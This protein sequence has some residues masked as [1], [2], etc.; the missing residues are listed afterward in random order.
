MLKSIFNPF[1]DRRKA[2]PKR[3]LE[4]ARSQTRNVVGSPWGSAFNNY[5]PERFNIGIL[6]EL[7]ANIPLL[8]AAIIKRQLLVGGYQFETFGDKGFKERLDL[9]NQTVKVNWLNQGL[10]TWWMELMD[11]AD[12]NGGGWGELVPT[13]TGSDIYHLKACKYD[14]FKFMAEES[15]KLRIGI[16]SENTFNYVPAEQEDYLYYL[17]FNQ[18]DGHPQGY[19]LLWGLPF[20][21]QILMRIWKSWDNSAWRFADPAMFITVKGGKDQDYASAKKTYDSILSSVSSV[22]Q[23]KHMGQTGDIGGA[24]KEGGDITIRFL[25]G[26]ETISEM[27]IPV[28]N[29]LEQ[30]ISATHIPPVLFGLNWAT[31]TGASATT[32]GQIDI[33]ISLI[34]KQ[35]ER[36]SYLLERVINTKL[37][38]TGD[39]GKK[40]KIIWDEINL[41]DEV[42]TSQA[43]KFNAEASEKEVQVQ[44][45]LIE[46]GMITLEEAEEN[47]RMR[48]LLRG[49]MNE[50]YLQKR[51]KALLVKKIMEN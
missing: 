6:R 17:A 1:G 13:K 9:F 50:D 36:I 46:Q 31:G 5:A 34:S 32:Q 21:G 15:G 8:N 49:K 30:I 2:E 4:P 3:E 26:D 16:K 11:S 18:R 24:V 33:L 47:L 41:Q 19:P 28:K 35:R 27:E 10:A 25:G 51:L 42:R 37:L 40:F 23:K 22:M 29:I 7:R 20:V 44:L 12:E 43:R 45:S 14:D 48:G 38:M 39:G